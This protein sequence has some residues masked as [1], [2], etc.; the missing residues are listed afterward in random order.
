MHIVLLDNRYAYDKET[1]DR[2][3]DQQW[4]WLN[5]TLKVKANLTIIGTG[6]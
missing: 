6:I 3:G 2:L 4:D 5:E 1:G